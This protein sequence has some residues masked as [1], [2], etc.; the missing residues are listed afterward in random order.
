MKLMT[1][2]EL[3]VV[4]SSEKFR[5][6]YDYDGMLGALYCEDQTIFRVWSPFAEYVEL[7]LYHDGDSSP[8]FEKVVLQKKEKGVW[9]FVKAGNACGI[10]YDYD[11]CVNGRIR[12]TADPYARAC[13]VNGVRSM[14]TDLLLTNPEGWEEDVCPPYET[15]QMIY[16]VHVK[17]FSFDPSGGFSEGVRGKYAAFLEDGT[18]LY[19]DGIHPT[20]LSYLK[21]LGVTHIQLMP[22]YDYGS[23]DEAGDGNEFNWGYDPMNYNVPEGSY[24]SDSYH[25]EVRIREMKE[26]IQ[27]LHRHGFRVIMDVVYN[28][29]YRADSWFQRMVPWYYYRQNE[30]GSMSDGSGC[31]NDVASERSMCG[32]YILD[33]VL[34]WAGEYHIDGFRFDLMGLLDVEL[35]NRIRRALDDRYGKNEKLVFGEPWAAADSPMEGK[36][37]PALKQNV[38]ELDLGIG[39][40]CDSTRDAVKGHIFEAE[41][42]GF[43]NGG[44]GFET[45]VL[46]GVDAWCDKNQVLWAKAP[47]QI[48]TYVS[49]HDNLTLW[50]K[51]IDT[52]DPDRQYHRRN[53]EIVR[54]YK[55]AAAIYLTCQ[56]NLFMLSGEEFLRTKE[57]ISDSFQ[58]PIEINRLDWK[59]A[60]EN[61]DIVKYYQEFISLRKILPGLCDKSEKAS[62]RITRK[63]QEQKGCVSFCVDNRSNDTETMWEQLYI[64]YNSGSKPVTLKLPE[65]EWEVLADGER[66]D[67]WKQTIRADGTYEAARTAVVVLGR[68]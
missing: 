62:E 2:K 44:D 14:V 21:N 42:P 26:M 38:R 54:V 68:K 57:G 59:Q 41:T 15:E 12:R 64:A 50:D 35:M 53:E 61:E 34:Y 49:S 30:D 67:L 29:T 33:S 8:A 28:H 4:Y 43:V 13:G 5:E 17:E 25:G 63:R 20:G 24:S 18:T 23:V 60:Y 56:G 55:L 6:T 36:S 40:F 22:S 52:M 39:V 66:A 10:Y 27:S 48:I 1:A 46:H 47:S 16:E 3:K 37:I 58:S 51:L 65:G 19:Q 45:S 9:E 31:G 32:R 11:V 7:N